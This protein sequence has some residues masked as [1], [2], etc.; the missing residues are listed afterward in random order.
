[1]EDCFGDGKRRADAIGEMRSISNV[2]EYKNAFFEI[3]AGRAAGIC[4]DNTGVKEIWRNGKEPLMLGDSNI[5]LA[6]KFTQKW[7]SL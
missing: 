5:I 6:R 2:H 4:N 1:M 7:G 3:G